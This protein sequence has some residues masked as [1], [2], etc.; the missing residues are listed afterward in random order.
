MHETVIAQGISFSI[1]A[2]WEATSSKLA[3]LRL[4]GR[5]AQTWQAK[6]LA[7]AAERFNYLYSD[8]ELAA[9][10]PLVKALEEKAHRVHVLFN[11]C[12]ADKGVRNAATFRAMLRA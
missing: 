5:N 12:Y 6:N 4:H 1:P 8:E 11:N 3:M 9:L 2:I 10:A 7:S